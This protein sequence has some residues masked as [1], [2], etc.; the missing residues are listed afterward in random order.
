MRS[1][2]RDSFPHLV[3]C[4][5]DL[6]EMVLTTALTR[7]VAWHWGIKIGLG[8]RFA[9]VPILRRSPGSSISIGSN[10]QFRSSPTSNLIGVNRKCVIATLFENAKVTIGD[11]SGL[12]GTVVSAASSISIGARVLVGSNTTITD[13][14]WHSL[15]PASRANGDRGRTSPVIIEDDVFIGTG[16]IILKGSKIGRCAVVGAGSVVSGTIPPFSVVTGNPGRIV[17]TLP[18]DH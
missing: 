4:I 15:G 2:S 13:T 14:D 1:L 5:I 3:S 17:K 6:S 7:L 11:A 12:S 18:S 8:S 9:G 10:C 16:V